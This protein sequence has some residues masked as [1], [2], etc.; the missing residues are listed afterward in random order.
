MRTGLRS[1][2][3][4]LLLFG[5]CPRIYSQDLWSGEIT[6]ANLGSFTYRATVTLYQDQANFIQRDS[7]LVNWGGG[8]SWLPRGSVVFNNSGVIAYTYQGTYTYP[9]PGNYTISTAD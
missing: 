4:V 9:G 5:N 7:L 3:I 6:Y 2:L 1:I 8:Q